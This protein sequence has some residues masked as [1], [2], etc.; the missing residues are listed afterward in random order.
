MA[1]KPARPAKI[2]RM[3]PRGRPPAPAARQELANYQPC[4][5]TALPAESDNAATPLSGNPPSGLT[6]YSRTIWN[7][8]CLEQQTHAA[9]GIAPHVTEAHGPVLYTYLKAFDELRATE[10]EARG[11]P[12]FI[13]TCQGVTKPNPV[14]VRL[15]S[16]RKEVASLGASL[17]LSKQTP[18]VAMQ[19]IQQNSAAQQAADPDSNLLMFDKFAGKVVN[20]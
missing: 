1:K 16:L 6:K 4:R 2:P 11:Q 8:I 7:Q 10:R 20:G 18:L 13:E 5:R 3:N 12:R 9:N 19:V 17:Q 14:H 15:S